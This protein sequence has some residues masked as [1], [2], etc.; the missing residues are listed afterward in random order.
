MRL[1]KDEY[2][3]LAKCLDIAKYDIVQDE[4]NH[5]EAI[6]PFM[7]MANSLQAKLS[8][9]AEDGR[10][11]SNILCTDNMDYTIERLIKKY[12]KKEYNRSMYSGPTQ[13][14]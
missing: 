12:S 4:F 10:R 8:Q 2:R 1:T 5:R 6:P 3:F 14:R 11:F 9:R 7:E 13:R